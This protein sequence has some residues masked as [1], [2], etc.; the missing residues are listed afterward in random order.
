[1]N[2]MNLPTFPF[3]QGKHLRYVLTMRKFKLSSKNWV[4][5][6][7][8]SATSNMTTFAIKIFLMGSQVILTNATFFKWYHKKVPTFGRLAEFP[9]PIF[10]KS[11]MKSQS[12]RYTNIIKCNRM[13]EV[14]YGLRFQSATKFIRH[15]HR[16]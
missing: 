7:I 1:M 10:A 6:K 14:W 11:H 9:E 8:L 2:K 4:F 5:Q 16:L 3:L 12:T 15:C 13:R